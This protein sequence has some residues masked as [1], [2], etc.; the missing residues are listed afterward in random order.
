VILDY[1]V[2]ES[3]IDEAE[4]LD[5][6]NYTEA[7]VKDFQKVLAEARELIDNSDDQESIDNMVTQ[8]EDAIKNLEKIEVI[9]DYSTLKSLI[10]EAEAL[11][12][13]N[14]TEASVKDFQRILAEAK[15]L[16]DNAD[17]QESIDSMVTRLQEAL[18]GL[19]E[20][21]TGKPTPPDKSDPN[22]DKT[23]KTDGIGETTLP[24][25]GEA[26]QTMF[27]IIGI[28]LIL[29]APIVNRKRSQKS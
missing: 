11:D 23:G 22:G 13:D 26:N 9:L 14:Y 20:K 18:E 27:W 15:E 1:S 21:E 4:A 6:D 16:I 25:S 12:L 2:L 10:D 7:S 5:L 3:L 17:D 29:A 19:I 28:G 24:K 8:L